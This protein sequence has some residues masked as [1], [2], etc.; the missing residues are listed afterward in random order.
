MQELAPSVSQMLISELSHEEKPF[1]ID[2]ILKSAGD[3]G[4][5]TPR[6]P[7]T[8]AATNISRAEIE[9]LVLKY[10]LNSQ[11]A[12]GRDIAEHLRLPFVL[13]QEIYAGLRAQMFIVYKNASSVSDYVYELTPAGVER[14]NAHRS[15]NTYFG[16][17]PVELEDYIASV[18]AQSISGVRVTFEQVAH[19][20]R[21][22][23]LTEA[24][25]TQ[26]GQA[27]NAGRGLF[28][29]GPPGNGKT[30]IAERLIGG[31]S[32]TIWIPR[33]ISVTG[34]LIRFYD[35]TSHELAEADPNGDTEIR[36]DRRWV[37]IKRP[38]VVV[39]GELNF[40]HLEIT[41][42]PTTNINE[43][44]LQLK[45]NCGVLVVDDFGRQRI[46]TEELLNRWIV[47]LEKGYDYLSLPSGRQI[48]VPFDQLLVFATN[49]EP[50]DLVDEAFLRRLPFKVQVNDP[51]EAQFKEMFRRECDAVGVPYDDALIS[52]LINSQ[53]KAIERQMRFCH[54][55]DLM[56]QVANYCDF[57]GKEIELSVE[58]LSV[59]CRNY[60]GGIEP[61]PQR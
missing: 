2:D 16:A 55:R 5:F 53:Y 46:S 40:K 12:N 61:T 49:L 35:P 57:S 32:D 3:G 6:E 43:S 58:T 30:T 27:I 23:V 44:P 18:K 59:A 28:L 48:Q 34:E 60:F 38:T 21:D 26:L 24:A 54:P 29:Y 14:A 33:T 13:M 50:Q 39:G 1:T 20:F 10:L 8:I 25:L 52:K 36:Y 47:P 51:T 17:A 4:R 56:F 22:M 9:G 11:T 42:N 45:S 31:V 41:T 7:A 19:A 37:R 15:R